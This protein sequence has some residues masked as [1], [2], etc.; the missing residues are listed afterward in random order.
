MNQMKFVLFVL[1]AILVD[2]EVAYY[3][4]ASDTLVCLNSK[5]PIELGVARAASAHQWVR[6]RI[7][8]DGLSH[9]YTDTLSR[10]C[11]CLYTRPLCIAICILRSFEVA[12]LHA[13]FQVSGFWPEW[14]LQGSEVQGCSQYGLAEILGFSKWITRIS[15]FQL[16]S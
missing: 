8:A 4:S 6:E 2:V 11:L 9:N 3:D 7:N 1:R 5:P 16:L 15:C 12:V 10:L 14:N 13:F